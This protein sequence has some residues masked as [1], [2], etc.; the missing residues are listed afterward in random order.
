MNFDFCNLTPAK[1]KKSFFQNIAERV[2]KDKPALNSFE[3]SLA[4]LDNAEIQKINSQHRGEKNPTDVLSFNLR[5]NLAEIFICP[6]QAQASA[7]KL[8]HSLK[9]ELSLL[10]IHGL[11]H[12]LGYNDEDDA[13]R[14]KMFKEQGMMLKN[15]AW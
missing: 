10:F 2:S 15:I 6:E 1:I 13:E 8:G 3:I 4:L 12:I 7:K 9:I 11:L 14:K 5:P